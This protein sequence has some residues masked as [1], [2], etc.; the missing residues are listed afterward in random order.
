MDEREMIL[1]R[2]RQSIENAKRL[3]LEWEKHIEDLTT[4]IEASEALNQK[5]SRLAHYD[6]KIYPTYES[7]L[8][9]Y[10]GHD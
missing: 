5:S 8:R 9:H 6:S 1:E 3:K 2:L 7:I 4:L 10:P